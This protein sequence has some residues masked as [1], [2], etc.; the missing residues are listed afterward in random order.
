[1]KCNSQGF[2]TEIKLGQF[3]IRIKLLYSINHC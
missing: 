2:L 3:I 1:M